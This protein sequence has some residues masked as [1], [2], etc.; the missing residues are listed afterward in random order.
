MKNYFDINGKT[1]EELINKYS[2]DIDGKTYVPSRL[3]DAIGR[4][5]VKQAARHP[6]DPGT[7]QNPIM[8]DGKAYVYNSRNKLIW[9]EDY[10]ETKQNSPKDEIFILTFSMKPNAEQCRMIQKA[11]SAPVLFTKDCPMITAENLANMKRF[12]SC[13]P[14]TAK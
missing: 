5:Q 10:E 4:R 9:W 14:L 2:V 1:D 8:K 11:E 13:R 12:T 6:G 7:I 3:L